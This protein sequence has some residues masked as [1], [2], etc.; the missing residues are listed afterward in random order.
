MIQTKLNICLMISTRLKNLR[1]VLARWTMNIE[2]AMMKNKR[3]V[4][5]FAILF[6]TLLYQPAFVFGDT[7]FFDPDGKIID[8][9]QYERSASDREK[10]LNIKLRDGYEFKSDVWKDP[11]TLRKTR[12][13]QWRIMRSHYN[14]D[15]LPAKIESPPPKNNWYEYFMKLDEK[16]LFIIL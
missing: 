16:L 6:C 11:I 7:I 14:P 13:E 4:S 10:I 8:K 1:W 15:S 5:F 3:F 9:A 2:V 12:I